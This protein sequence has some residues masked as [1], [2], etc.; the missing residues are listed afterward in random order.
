MQLQSVF[1]VLLLIAA[2]INES[3]SENTNGKQV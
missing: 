3:K 2:Y 1:A